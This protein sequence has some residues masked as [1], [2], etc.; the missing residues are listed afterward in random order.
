MIYI[1]VLVVVI[2]QQPPQPEEPE[3]EVAP[4]PPAANPLQ[5]RCPACG[6]SKLYTNMESA[7]KGLAAH[8]QHCAGPSSNISPFSLPFRK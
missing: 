4:T 5:P 1:G 7:R 3:K 6:W 2:V 8:K